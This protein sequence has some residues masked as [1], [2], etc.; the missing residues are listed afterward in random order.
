MTNERLRSAITGAGMTIDLLSAQLGVDP[1]TIERWITKERVP[2]R[3][4]RMAVAVALGKDD[5]FLWPS[6][7]SDT[8][9]QS[10]SQAEFVAMHPSR[11]SVPANTWTSLLDQ[12]KESI[13]LLAYAASFLHD[14]VPDFGPQLMEKA[15]QGVQVRLLFGDPT[16]EAVQRR[17]EEEGIKHL[18]G[19]RC[20]LTW[21]YFTPVLTVPGVTARQHGETLYNSIF[22]F[23]DVLLANTHT[24]G[25][26]ASQSPIIHVQRIVGGRLFTTYMQSFE[27]TWDRAAEVSKLEVA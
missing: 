25:A 8:R 20:E 13:D 14:S 2:H 15:R 26:P 18:L 22:R 12:A 11:G 6:T 5:V 17:G 27:R 23:D 9:T 3:A 21:A 7:L 4:H 24:F 1:K 16:S 19:S 10:A